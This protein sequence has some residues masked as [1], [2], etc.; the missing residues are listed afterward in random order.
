MESGRHC[1][2]RVK[3]FHISL[4]K[5]IPECS[6][7]NKKMTLLST[8]DLLSLIKTTLTIFSLNSIQLLRLSLHQSDLLYVLAM[9]VSLTNSR[10][11]SV[12]PSMILRK[13]PSVPTWTPSSSQEQLITSLHSMMTLIFNT[14]TSQIFLMHN[15][16]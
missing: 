5:M 16:V 7:S 11:S 6:I 15:T 3:S 10:A 13:F 14:L 9:A 4:W 1:S 12:L 2:L 8:S